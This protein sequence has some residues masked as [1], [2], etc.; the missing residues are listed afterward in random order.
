MQGRGRGAD[1][2]TGQAGSAAAR[3]VP[4]GLAYCIPEPGPSQPPAR[5]RTPDPDPPRQAL[6]VGPPGVAGAR[7]V[8][9]RRGRQAA[10]LR[11][12]P[13]GRAARSSPPRAPHPG[14]P[15]PRAR[16]R[17]GAALPGRGRL[18]PGPAPRRVSGGSAGGGV[19]SRG[20]RPG[21]GS[22]GGGARGPGRRA[23]RRPSL[24]G[25]VNSPGASAEPA[26]R[27]APTQLPSNRLA[28]ARPAPAPLPPRAQTFPQSA[29]ARPARRALGLN[30]RGAGGL[31]AGRLPGA[32]PRPRP[33]PAP[34]PSPPYPAQPP[35]P[36]PRP[37]PTPPPPRHAPPP[38]LP[39]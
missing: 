33:G 3:A 36:R 27:P 9:P 35:P 31:R 14:A 22:R 24:R 39:G 38:P 17:D 5:S 21:P 20:W 7:R 12:G 25:F 8:S 29:C 18:G 34:S 6:P 1:R 2:T 37:A 13:A 19:E 28:P 11:A 4:G 23:A 16:P 26:A 32:R 30:P 10:G 15:R